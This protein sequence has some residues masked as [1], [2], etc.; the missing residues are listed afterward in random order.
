[1][2]CPST[3]ERWRFPW[4]IKMPVA[5][6]NIVQV[7]FLMGNLPLIDPEHVAPCLQRAAS[8][9][10]IS[11][12]QKNYC[13]FRQIQDNSSR[14]APCLSLIN[15]SAQHWKK[16]P[17]WPLPKLASFK[18]SLLWIIWKISRPELTS[19]QIHKAKNL[20]VRLGMIPNIFQSL[21]SVNYF[22]FF[23]LNWKKK[24]PLYLHFRQHLHGFKIPWNTFPAGQ[25][26][27]QFV[28]GLKMRI[29]L[30]SIIKWIHFLGSEH[31]F[32][33]KHIPKKRSP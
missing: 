4:Q 11:G 13:L 20:K 7:L 19:C 32:P 16:K 9:F 17:H 12:C 15:C 14:A 3:G 27:K 24:N 31:L 2:T 21:I 10:P 1:M 28:A 5:I 22:L 25:C 29:F 23:S 8:N 6:W 26:S 18:A 33:C 30:P